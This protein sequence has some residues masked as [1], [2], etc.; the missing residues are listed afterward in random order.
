ME[1]SSDAS[2]TRSSSSLSLIKFKGVLPKYFNSEWSFAQ[3]HLSEGSHYTVAFG[4]Q[5]NTV[6]ILGMDGSFYRCQFDPVHGGEMT[7]LESHNFL[8]PEIA[9]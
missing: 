5:K 8:K 1:S 2:I 7:Q 4:H 3:F 6:I 9:S